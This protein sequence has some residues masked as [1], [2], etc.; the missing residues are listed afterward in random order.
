MI[1]LF[2]NKEEH[3]FDIQFKLPL[4]IDKLDKKSGGWSK[5]IKPNRDNYLGE[6]IHKNLIRYGGMILV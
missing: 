5:Y 6:S 4:V 1:A 2:V 3:I